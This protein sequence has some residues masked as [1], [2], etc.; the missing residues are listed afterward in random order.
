MDCGPSVDVNEQ[1]T[2]LN[3]MDRD[4]GDVC[5]STAAS[6]APPSV[7]SSHKTELTMPSTSSS[8]TE[9]VEIVSISNAIRAFFPTVFHG[10]WTWHIEQ[11]LVTNFKDNTVVGIF[12]DA[13]R[14][15]RMTEFQTKWDELRSFPDGAV[16]KYLE[17]I[18]LYS[19]HGGM[20]QL[21]FYERRN[22]WTSRTTLH[23]NYSETRLASEADKGRR[24]RVEPIDCYRV[25]VRDNR[26]DDIVNLHT[27]ECTCKEFNSFSIPCPHAIVAAK[28]RNI[29]IRSLC[30]RFYIV[31]SLM[32]V[33]AKPINPLG[34]ISECKR[35]FGYVEKTILPPK[36]VAQVGRRR[37]RRIPSR[38]E[39][40]RQMK[41]VRCGNYGHNHQNCSELLT[42]V[43][44]AKNVRNRDTKTS[45][46]V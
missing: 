20:L 14:A 17:D 46:L 16:M 7:S 39:F 37:V 28:E 43:Q 8:R 25:H 32:T 2:G 21:W 24:Y 45:H 19:G 18:G 11:N 26:L 3:K 12:R 6:V 38:G 34:H 23:S 33:Y 29:P 10:L 5:R 35:P 22:Y 36:F 40:H 15:F 27:R 31:D 42:T 13:A 30:S 1:P 41:C 9:D 4:H 44:R